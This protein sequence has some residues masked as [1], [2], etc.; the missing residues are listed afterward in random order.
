MTACASAGR[1]LNGVLRFNEGGVPSLNSLSQPK[2][3][4]RAPTTEASSL[5]SE[6][7][8]VSS[9]CIPRPS[10][11]FSK[12][13]IPSLYP[14]YEH[15]IKCALDSKDFSPS[16]YSRFYRERGRESDDSWNQ[17]PELRQHRLFLYLV[18]AA[19]AVFYR[20]NSSDSDDDSPGLSP[21][22]STPFNNTLKRLRFT[23]TGGLM[24]GLGTLGVL[25][26][27][28]PESKSRNDDMLK[29]INLT[30]M[31]M[32]TATS[33]EEQLP[34]KRKLFQNLEEMFNL[35]SGPSQPDKK[36]TASPPQKA[37]TDR[38]VFE[39][40]VKGDKLVLTEGDITKHQWKALSSFLASCPHITSL[41]LQGIEISAED[42]DELGKGLQQLRHLT[43]CDN[44]I[45]LHEGSLER[46]VALLLCCGLLE[47]TSIIRN[48]LDDQHIPQLVKLMKDHTSL[49]RVSFCWNGI[50]DKGANQMAS[51]IAVL[52][53]SLKDIDLS[54]NL[55]GP[56]GKARLLEASR[57]RVAHFG[58]SLRSPLNIHLRHNERFLYFKREYRAISGDFLAGAGS[59][60]WY[61]RRS[62][63]NKENFYPKYK[64]S[65]KI[66][67]D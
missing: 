19:P 60:P 34:F 21:P 43:F 3:P 42:A 27:A 1:A 24:L 67:G 54:Y 57:K 39:R 5:H 11:A 40:L 20:A 63:F 10:Q 36:K 46:L 35:S 62:L 45:G 31:G 26:Y 47:S 33:P 37:D 6:F 41:R 38:H 64:K 15:L 28:K 58:N 32:K 55:I 61:M 30:A 66:P 52:N 7:R 65:K 9:S 8:T 29:G 48:S 2:A 16:A 59:N 53:T 14:H 56:D 12:S 51:A 25:A 50:S 17:D 22:L 44:S 49:T 23:G 4:F 18:S 13:S